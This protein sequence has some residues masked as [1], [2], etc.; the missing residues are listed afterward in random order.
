MAIRA[1]RSP[2]QPPSGAF[3]I[4]HARV[5]DEMTRSNAAGKAWLAK[6]LWDLDTVQFGN[7]N[8]GRTVN[9][10]VYVNLRLLVSNPRVLGRVGRVIKEESETLLTMLHQ[11]MAPFSRC[12]GV[13]FGG[14]HIS[15]AFSMT[16][17]VPMIYLHPS[18]DGSGD[19]IEGAYVPGQTVL[20]I[21]DL[22]TGGTSVIE[23]GRHLREAGLHVRDA[24]VLV[25][26]QQGAKERLK[27][28][29]I[30]LIPILELETLLNWGMAHGRIR[31]ETQYRDSIE[32]L[33][34]Q[35]DEGRRGTG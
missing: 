17:K 11:H 10:P 28:Q 18:K 31:D 34:R 2:A 27:L 26:R 9:S 20:V 6:A 23:T 1:R 16:A 33:H 4:L 30:N 8:V 19:V 25:D 7:F 14:L 29:G 15:T 22:I 3:D 24:I 21:D 32:F 35:A 12:A 5:G 13:P